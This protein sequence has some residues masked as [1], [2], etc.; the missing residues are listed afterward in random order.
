[1]LRETSMA[2]ARS[3]S[4]CSAAPAHGIWISASAAPNRHRENGFDTEPNLV[5]DK[6]RYIRWVQTQ[7]P[8]ATKR[9]RSHQP[10]GRL[11]GTPSRCQHKHEDPGS[12]N[13]FAA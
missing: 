12:S 11:G 4:A 7:A 5:S 13:V 1:M 10:R 3:R 9:S 2:R 8:T 6:T